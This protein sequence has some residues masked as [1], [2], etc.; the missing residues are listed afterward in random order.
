MEAGVGNIK[1]LKNGSCK[2]GRR[3]GH[4]QTRDR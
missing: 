2:V 1:W 4:E 3:A